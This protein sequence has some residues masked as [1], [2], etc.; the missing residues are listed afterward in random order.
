M[1]TDMARSRQL[2][3][4]TKPVLDALLADSGWEFVRFTDQVTVGDADIDHIAELRSGP[5]QVRLLVETELH[6]RLSAVSSESGRLQSIAGRGKTPTAVAVFAD[7]ITKGLASALRSA[8]VGYFDLYGTCYLRWPGLFIDRPGGEEPLL[9]EADW[10]QLGAILTTAAGDVSAQNVLGPRP[11]MRHRVVRAM[12]SEPERKWHQNELAQLLHVDA[13]SHVYRTLRFLLQEHYADF[14]GKGPSKVVFLTRPGE[15]LDAWAGMWGEIWRRLLRASSTFYSLTTDLDELSTEL[16]IA[17]NDVDAR[18]GLTLGSGANCFGSY[19]RDDQVCA[20]VSD[21]IPAIAQAMGLEPVERGA[22]V[23][24]VPARDEGLFYL[25]HEVLANLK[26]PQ[27]RNAGPVCPVQLYLDMHAAGG[28]YAEQAVRLR[29]E[30]L[31]Y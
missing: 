23:T 1:R 28:R 20:Y 2:E 18:V 15:L 25:P 9:A 24:L 8:G 22:N 13:A 4:L 30:V 6:P 16:T 7:R 26:T 10:P 31:P 29:E 19:L 5:L 27:P 11:V 3:T 17:A 12:L 14:V 21:N